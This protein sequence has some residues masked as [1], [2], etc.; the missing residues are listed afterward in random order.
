MGISVVSRN[1]WLYNQITS[2]GSVIQE[3]CGS[4]ARSCGA[5]MLRCCCHT[6]STGHVPFP[7]Y[8]TLDA[9]H[10]NCFNTHMMYSYDLLY[11]CF[12]N[13][14]TTSNVPTVGL[15]RPLQTCHGWSIWSTSSSFAPKTG[16]R[17]DQ[18]RNR[19]SSKQSRDPTAACTNTASM[20][21]SAARLRVD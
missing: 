9:N 13:G 20:E 1:G 5:M 16:A 3:S 8:R 2:R 7:R 21:K 12:T 18:A 10:G 15:Y 14:Q 17:Q 11:R 6:K 4:V 19:V